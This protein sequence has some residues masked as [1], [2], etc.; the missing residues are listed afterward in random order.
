LCFAF[1]VPEEDLKKGAIT[2][3]T[4]L[5]FL[6]HE[7]HGTP[8]AFAYTDPTFRIEPSHDCID[9]G[10]AGFWA[11]VGEKNERAC[12]VINPRGPATC[13]LGPAELKILAR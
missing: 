10:S 12:L 9:I 3:D 6:Q 2:A 5:Q 11:F 13:V 7:W 4:R 8:C 1:S